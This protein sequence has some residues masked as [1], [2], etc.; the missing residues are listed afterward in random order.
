MVLVLGPHRPA[1]V[2]WTGL[3]LCPH[4]NLPFTAVP[5]KTWQLMYWFLVPVILDLQFT[6]GYLLVT[7]TSWSSLFEYFKY[8][9]FGSLYDVVS[10]GSCETWLMSTIVELD[11][12]PLHSEFLKCFPAMEPESPCWWLGLRIWLAL[13][14]TVS[15][16][17]KKNGLFF[18]LF[19]VWL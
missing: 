6:V 12:N 16:Y 5:I 11:Q 18:V 10:R 9:D 4:L 17:A 14:G 13:N 1:I 7:L 3:E 15:N 19:C 2:F 8:S